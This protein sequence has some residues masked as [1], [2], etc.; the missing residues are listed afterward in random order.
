MRTC[1]RLA[2]T[3]V[4]VAAVTATATADAAT[5]PGTN[6]RIVYGQVFPNYGFTIDEHGGDVHAIGP[7]DSTTCDTLSPDGTKVLCNLWGDTG[8]QPATANPD[9]S[10]FTLLDQQ[11]PFDLF[12]LT[13]SPDGT[14]LLC[15]SEGMADPAD[16]GL[17]SVR[18][19]DAGD[20]VR[21]STTPPGGF[22]IGYAFSPDGSRVLYSQ[23]DG[24]GHMGLFSVPAGGGAATRLSARGLHVI[25]L[26]FFDRVG[27]DWS[28]DG[29][30]SVFAAFDVA[31]RRGNSAVYVVD[32]DG[33]HQQR[34]TPAGV[35]G[36]SAQ[37]SPDGGRIAFTSGCCGALGAWTIRPD[38]TGL[39]EVAHPAGGADYL[40]PVWSPD[41]EELVVNRLTRTGQASLWVVG[42]NG[43]H[44]TKLADTLSA[45]LYDWGRAV[46]AGR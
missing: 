22:D 43:S 5:L 46:S 38:G 40:T 39:R 18:A 16:A 19:S 42:A 24:S 21:L 13:W 36:I 2:I 7:A 11:L 25:D 31:G 26:G 30:R 1:T 20:I 10:D 41:S 23:D 6:G 29:S 27:A 35:G 3:A 14:R 45:S 32:A 9:G 33:G 17:Y 44:L 4:V 12:C 37:W 34:V 28:P 15:H 8:V